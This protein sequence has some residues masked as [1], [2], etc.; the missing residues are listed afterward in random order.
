MIFF[1]SKIELLS[2]EQSR[3]NNADIFLLL[4][5]NTSR[6]LRKKFEPQITKSQLIGHRFSKKRDQ[7]IDSNMDPARTSADFST[8]DQVIFILK[9][10][11]DLNFLFYLQSESSS[12]TQTNDLN[13]SAESITDEVHRSE[14]VFLRTSNRVIAPFTLF[15]IPLT[16]DMSVLILVEVKYQIL[17]TTNKEF[18]SDNFSSGKIVQS[19]R[20]YSNLSVISILVL[21]IVYFRIIH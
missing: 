16:N 6:K 13:S 4:L 12:N 20:I 17:I 1:F 7:I 8:S 3:P 14:V 18:Q 15:T 19:V 10:T 5:N 9:Q 2:P 21:P 11:S